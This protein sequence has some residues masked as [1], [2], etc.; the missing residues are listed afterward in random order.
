MTR[1]LSYI[2][3]SHNFFVENSQT[4]MGYPYTIKTRLR[5]PYAYLKFMFLQTKFYIKYMLPAKLDA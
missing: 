4:Y 3:D 5:Y 1:I 2:I